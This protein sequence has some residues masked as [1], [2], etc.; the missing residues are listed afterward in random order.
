MGKT[1]NNNCLPHWD[2]PLDNTRIFHKYSRLCCCK[3]LLS[4]CQACIRL[5]SHRESS[6]FLH[7]IH[8]VDQKVWSALTNPTHVS[9]MAG[10]LRCIFNVSRISRLFTLALA[11]HCQVHEY[12]FIDT[13]RVYLE[14][15]V[16]FPGILRTLD[17]LNFSGEFDS[18]SQ[19]Q[20]RASVG[21]S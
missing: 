1:K 17:N 8:T 7:H 13:D 5:P 9:A 16:P 3:A 4:Y 14:H 20:S 19:P 10:T 18:L 15:L 12:S 6:D 21:L 11:H 2:F